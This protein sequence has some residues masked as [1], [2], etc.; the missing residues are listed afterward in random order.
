MSLA[1]VTGAFPAQRAS[2]AEKGSIW[3]RHHDSSHFT[4]LQS[5]ISNPFSNCFQ[6]S[7]TI[8]HH[9]FMMIV[10]SKTTSQSLNWHSLP[11][12]MSIRHSA[13]IKFVQ[14]RY[15]YRRIWEI[16]VIVSNFIM[17]MWRLCLKQP[18]LFT[19][20]P[21]KTK[22]EANKNS[23]HNLILLWNSQFYY[24][25]GHFRRVQIITWTIMTKLHTLLC[26]C[27]WFQWLF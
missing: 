25:H 21:S 16:V 17:K 2:E 8:N 24:R 20:K 26:S 23:Q 12:H 5:T 18:L 22:N 10:C 11:R 3:W 19:T 6:W 9:F 14:L 13:S 7:I 27:N 15:V 1:S 4:V